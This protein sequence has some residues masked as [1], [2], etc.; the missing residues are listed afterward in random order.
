[1]YIDDIVRTY[2]IIYGT[3]NCQSDSLHERN[4]IS[5]PQ[6]G[7]RSYSTAE[8]NEPLTFD[9]YV[10]AYKLTERKVIS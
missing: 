10:I 2:Y 9:Y 4:I 6:Y 5:A 3:Y 7:R 8:S 1:M